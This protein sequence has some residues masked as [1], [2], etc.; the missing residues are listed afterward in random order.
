MEPAFYGRPFVGAK[1]TVSFLS[2]LLPLWRHRAHRRAFARHIFLYGASACA[3]LGNVSDRG[4]PA[5]LFLD[6]LYDSPRF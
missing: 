4:I 5:V 6:A 3:R 1:D 2:K